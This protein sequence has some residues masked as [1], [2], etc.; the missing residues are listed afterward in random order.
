M[1]QQVCLGYRNEG[2]LW[3]LRW[4][5]MLNQGCKDK[6][7]LESCLPTLMKRY[8]HS[9]ARG[10]KILPSLSIDFWLFYDEAE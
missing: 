4:K 2:Q 7:L 1:E 9:L 10:E 6:N 5:C 3:D 8:T